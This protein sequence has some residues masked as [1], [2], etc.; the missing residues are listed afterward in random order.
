MPVPTVQLYEEYIDIKL[1]LS[2]QRISHTLSLVLNIPPEALLTAP[3]LL[4]LSLMYNIPEEL[5][6]HEIIGVIP[7]LMAEYAEYISTKKNTLW[8]T[9]PEQQ[10]RL[11]FAY[12][13]TLLCDKSRTEHDINRIKQH[14]IEPIKSMLLNH[15]LNN[16]TANIN[17]FSYLL[18]AFINKT[19][20]IDGW[21]FSTEATLEQEDL[22]YHQH[23]YGL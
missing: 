12:E 10:E 7:F 2:L 1:N 21:D 23:A 16:K 4:S 15:M 20:G 17:V 6:Q 8:S 18:Q 22:K 5:I 9:Q 13:I 11:D 14:Y 3:S 19:S